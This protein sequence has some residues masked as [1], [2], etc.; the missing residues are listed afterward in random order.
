M[1]PQTREAVV[2]RI[3]DEAR[4][5]KT[6]GLELA[7]GETFE[8]LP[9]QSAAVAIPGEPG[10]RCVVPIGSSPLDAPVIEVTL[11][12]DLPDRLRGVQGG[13]TLTIDGPHGDFLYRDDYKHAVLIS[14]EGDITPYRSIMRY[15]LGKGLPNRLS[16]IY[17]EPEPARMLFRRELEEF[18][19]Q[20]V[21]VHA[22]ITAPRGTPEDE[23]WD[24][25]TGPI[26]L[27][28]IRKHA[29]RPRE[30]A[31]FLTGPPGFVGE[32]KRALIKAGAKRN[33]VFSQA[34]DA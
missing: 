32:L 26:K 17:A 23:P 34:R 31:F 33:A 20:G 12:P 16:L 30:T 15:V 10:R 6:L 4:G 18:A 2:S 8:F 28:V 1:G 11:G 25:P 24:G 21:D 9:G 13:E 19:R 3:V 29:P 22:T 7:S 27:A 5:T 14:S